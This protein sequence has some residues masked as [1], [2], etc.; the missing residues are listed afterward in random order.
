MFL[1]FSTRA[2]VWEPIALAIRQLA[3]IG[4]GDLLNPWHLAPEVGL[5]VIDGHTALDSL[6]SDD[7]TSLLGAGGHKWSGGVFPQPLPDGTFLC[8]LNPTHSVHRNKITLMEEIVHRYL[9]H[10]PSQLTMV[11]EGCRVR[12]YNK[13]CEEEAYGVGAAALLPW[14]TFFPA[15]NGGQTIEELAEA[16]EVTPQLIAYRIKITGAFRLYRARQQQHA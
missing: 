11:A 15:V 14:H 4:P 3:Q 5:R 13:A 16:S 2:K 12:D 6:T 7:R 9:Q 10:K 8:I 1:P